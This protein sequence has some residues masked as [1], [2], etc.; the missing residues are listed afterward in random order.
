MILVDRNQLSQVVRNLVSNAIKFSGKDSSVKIN[1]DI[2]PT[3]LLLKYSMSNK[4]HIQNKIF[5]NNKKIINFVKF[6]VTDM[7]AGISKVIDYIVQLK[8]YSVINS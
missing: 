8:C 5:V 6:S 3:D 2:M 4:L 1:I 7:G